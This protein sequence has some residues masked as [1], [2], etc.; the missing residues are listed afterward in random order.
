MEVAH[1]GLTITCWPDVLAGVSLRVSK[2]MAATHEVMGQRDYILGQPAQH[3]AHEH[4]R[5]G[6][7]GWPGG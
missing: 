4:G 7:G 5:A 6:T 3:P 2:Q 1:L